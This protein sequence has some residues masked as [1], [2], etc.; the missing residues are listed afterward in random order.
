[1]V[2]FFACALTFAI[3][4][5]C[6]KDNQPQFNRYQFLAIPERQWNDNI[7]YFESIVDTPELRMG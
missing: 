4:F 6:A 2:L 5:L 1:M 7:Q 3:P